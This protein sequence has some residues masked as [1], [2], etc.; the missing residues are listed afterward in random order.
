MK[1]QHYILL[2][3]PKYYPDPFVLAE[4][5]NIPK[6]MNRLSTR[7]KHLLMQNITPTYERVLPDYQFAT[8]L[9]S[10][11]Q[12]LSWIKGEVKNMPI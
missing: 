2:V 8:V 1:H 10:T 11:P 12:N 5:H 3:L 7:E 4:V 6:M 9:D